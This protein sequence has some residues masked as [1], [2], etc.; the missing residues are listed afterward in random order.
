MEQIKAA[1]K[2]I[3]AYAESQLTSLE[4]KR[5]EVIKQAKLDY[6]KSSVDPEIAKLQKAK[7]E[8]VKEANEEYS[9]KISDL[10][11]TF[12]LTCEALKQKADEFVEKDEMFKFETQVNSIKEFIGKLKAD[13]QE[14]A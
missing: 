12:N 8:A 9:K 7:D 1:T 2:S 11:N 13:I 4:H 10:N 14:E 6:R 3:I 5:D